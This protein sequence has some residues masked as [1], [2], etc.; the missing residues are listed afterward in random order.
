MQ[1]Y[2]QHSNKMSEICQAVK[3]IH[4]HTQTQT[5][6]N[7]KFRFQ[8][9]QCIPSDSVVDRYDYIVYC[10]RGNLK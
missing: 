1:I 5:Q 9:F 10:F 6:I 4:T 2:Q 7:P 8:L 3:Q